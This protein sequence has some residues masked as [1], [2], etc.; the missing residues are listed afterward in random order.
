MKHNEIK[1]YFKKK[2]VQE[3]TNHDVLSIDESLSS[4]VLYV[5]EKDTLRTT[6]VIRCWF[7]TNDYHISAYV[8]NN[9]HLKGEKLNQYKDQFIE[10]KGNYNQLHKLNIIMVAVKKHLGY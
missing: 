3:L 1:A 5:I 4:R 6:T 10:V 9:K 8:V 7:A 2:L